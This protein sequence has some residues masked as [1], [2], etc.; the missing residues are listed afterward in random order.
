M[1]I[2]FLSSFTLI[3]VQVEAPLGSIEVIGIDL[4]KTASKFLLPYPKGP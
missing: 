4:V 3:I 2:K 1:A